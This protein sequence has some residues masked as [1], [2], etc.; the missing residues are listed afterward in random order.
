MRAHRCMGI[1]SDVGPMLGIVRIG[2]AENPSDFVTDHVQGLTIARGK[3]RPGSA[4]AHAAFH[5]LS[6]LP[7]SFYAAVLVVAVG[8]LVHRNAERCKQVEER[9]S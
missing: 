6:Q 7:D 9:H 3:A 4:V 8:G 5:Q 1:P 2:A